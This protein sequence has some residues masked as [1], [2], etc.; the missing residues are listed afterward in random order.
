[1]EF[2]TKEEFVEKYK[3]FTTAT[4]PTWYISA[5]SEMIFS[6]VSINKRDTSWDTT[7]VPLFIKNASME[8]LRFM[9]EHDLPFIDSDH[10]KA[11]SMDATL[12]SDYSTLA[13]RM[14]ANGGYM[15]RGTSR[16]MGISIPINQ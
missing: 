15:Y 16:K 7:S 13:L 2:F 4:I 12:K 14:L 9:L 8:Q 1:M 5:A 3:E 10:I 11:G 6:Q